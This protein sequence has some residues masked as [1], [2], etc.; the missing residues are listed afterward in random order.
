M[1]CAIWER[2]YNFKNVKNTQIRVLLLVK[3]H[4]NLKLNLLKQP[5]EVPCIKSCYEKF[6]KFHR[7]ILTQESL[8]NKLY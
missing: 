5:P 1:L 8:F 4:N 3:G 6:P 7:K 2:L